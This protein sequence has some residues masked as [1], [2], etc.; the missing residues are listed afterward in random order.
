M[1]YGG[2]LVRSR[3]VGK[4]AKGRLIIAELECQSSLALG[5]LQHRI[6][7]L[8]EFAVDKCRL[9]SWL[10]CWQIQVHQRIFGP[11]TSSTQHT[12]RVEIVPSSS[13][14]VTS[15]ALLAPPYP[16]AELS[17]NCTK[18]NQSSQICQNIAATSHMAQI[19]TNK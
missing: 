19:P 16:P 10:T 7:V 17:P 8:P 6:S 12:E 13:S 18:M 2:F 4:F 11:Y 9:E 15:A 14:S 5:P 1:L 3:L